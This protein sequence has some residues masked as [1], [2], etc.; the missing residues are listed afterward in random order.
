M[1]CSSENQRRRRLHWHSKVVTTLL[2]DDFE[3]ACA[4]YEIIDDGDEE[5]IMEMRKKLLREER[6][7][8]PL[9]LIQNNKIKHKVIMCYYMLQPKWN[10]VRRN[11]NVF[12][13]KRLKS[14][15]FESMKIKMFQNFVQKPFSI[16]HNK[17]HI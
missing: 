10:V 3:G 12:Q 6:E 9:I 5:K 7:R 15:F 16:L 17:K 2:V 4:F 13:N 8:C 14:L 11:F 1:S